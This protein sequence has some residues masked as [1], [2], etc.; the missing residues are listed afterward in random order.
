MFLHFLKTEE[1]M[2]KNWGA[3]IKY[4]GQN[5]SGLCDDIS[6]G[7]YCTCRVT[8]GSVKSRSF[9]KET[10]LLFTVCSDGVD[11]ILKDKNHIS[12]LVEDLEKGTDLYQSLENVLTM[13]G[14]DWYIDSVIKNRGKKNVCPGLDD[15]SLV[16]VFI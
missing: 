2:F 3:R 14:N 10:Q 13:E 7:K 4:G 15:M 9:P 5:L 6:Y 1:Y 11:D 8:K 16:Y 12:D